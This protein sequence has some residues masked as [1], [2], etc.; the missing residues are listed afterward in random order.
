MF[1]ITSNTL[2]HDML[3]SF[4]TFINQFDPSLRDGPTILTV[5]GGIDSMVMLHLFHKAGL[6]AVVAHCNFGLRG[7]A[8]MGDEQFVKE[9][10]ETYRYPFY[11]NHFN[12]KEYASK[13]GVSTQMAARE[14][15]YSWFELLRKELNLNWVATAHHINDSLETSLINFSRGTSIAGLAGIAVVNIHIIRPLL[16]ANRS[17]LLQ[18]LQENGIAW[19]EDSS[20]ASLDYD[21]NVIRHKVIPILKGLNESLE[22]SFVATSE[23]LRAGEN[24][25]NEY[26]DQWR[27]SV[28]EKRSGVYYI[29]IAQI[30]LVSEPNYR[31]WFIL[32]DFGF[33]YKQIP[34]IYAARKGLSGKVFFSTKH[35]LLV[36]RDNFIIQPENEISIFEPVFI[37]GPNEE[38]M[39]DI[40]KLN[41]SLVQNKDF[42]PIFHKNKCYLDASVIQFPLLIR[43]LELGD[44]IKPFG[45]K[46]RSKKVS[47]ILIDLKLN[48]FEKKKIRVLVNGDNEII[49]ILGI[50]LSD[51]FR[52]TDTTTYLLKVELLLNQIY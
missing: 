6:P 50:R 51:T 14:L 12:T 45:M 35:V 47:D 26:L 37:A 46:G 33:T 1:K 22:N 48:V 49:W 42:E 25:L 28:L 27:S 7:E 2:E 17:Q 20:N 38:I 10:A 32:K 41:V 4:L 9:V 36:D 43:K 52:V 30:E 5:S 15:R 39:L 34:G 44:K 13:N 29:S 3:D 16:F 18:Y 23:K 31:L 21:R 40:G 24:I 19:R 8:S 11:V